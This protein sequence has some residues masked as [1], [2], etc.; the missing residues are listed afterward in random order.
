M[1]LR[2]LAATCVVDESEDVQGW[3]VDCW[4]LSDESM[5]AMRKAYQNLLVPPAIAAALV[6]LEGDGLNLDEIFSDDSGADQENLNRIIR[7]D[8]LELAAAS[9]MVAIEKIPLETLVMPNVPKGSLKQSAPGIDIL[10]A[11]L[12]ANGDP[13]QLDEDELLFIGSVKHTLADIAGLRND[14]D[15]SVSERTLSMTYLGPQLRVLHGRLQERGIDVT[16]LLLVLRSTPLLS[17][18][19][20]RIVAVGAVECQDREQFIAQLPRLS[21]CEPGLK[22]LRCMLVQGLA[23]LHSQESE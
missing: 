1:E 19:H 12:H 10:S 15:R 3:S 11:R 14:L 22:R 5:K 7:A 18:K 13:R 20:I 4:E 8:M 2:A 21:Q 6:D 16:R 23:S 17:S 9:S